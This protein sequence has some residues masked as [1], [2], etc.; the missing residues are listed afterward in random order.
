MKSPK[1]KTYAR[2]KFVVYERA[3]SGALTRTGKRV[4]L[5][6]YDVLASHCAREDGLLGWSEKT[7]YW[8]K[9]TGEAVGLAPLSA[10]AQ[11]EVSAMHGILYRR[12]LD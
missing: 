12:A 9:P 11:E 3:E 5:S 8:N 1:Q 7:I 10:V 6:A 2:L 4:S